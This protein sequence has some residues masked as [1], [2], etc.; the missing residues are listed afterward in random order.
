MGITRLP[1]FIVGPHLRDGRLEVVLPAFPLPDQGIHAVYPHHRN[2]S[3]KVRVFVDFLAER[4][5][6]EPYWDA[7]LDL[8]AAPAL[9]VKGG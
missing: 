4:F 3:V 6:P 9:A 1:T 2:L 7:G 8:P 5:G